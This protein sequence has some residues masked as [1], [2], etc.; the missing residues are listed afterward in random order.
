MIL[1]IK[2]DS[3]FIEYK[4]R[5]EN[6]KVTFTIK[7][8]FQDWWTNFLKT[9]PNLTIRDGVFSNVERMLKCQSWGLGYTIYKCPKCG[10][11]KSFHILVSL[12]SVLPVVINIANN[13]Q[14][15]FSLNYLDVN[16]NMLFLLF[17]MN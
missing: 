12:E 17:Q 10:E 13:V 4:D 11:E 7:E 2:I 15:L 3:N 1:C 9:Y 6:R 14:L 5:V 8:I 16:I